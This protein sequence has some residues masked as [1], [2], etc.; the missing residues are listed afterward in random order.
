M[1]EKQES[2]KKQAELTEQPMH[3][4]ETG[5]IT[6]YIWRRQSPSGFAYFDYDLKRSFRSLSSGANASS[7]NF[8]ACNRHD[9][10][11]AVA[12]ASEWIEANEGNA[13]TRNAP[14]A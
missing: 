9:L 3:M 14:A 12:L 2:R 1:T 7:R 8:F 10:L 13:N 6:A 5:A 11:Q 4:I